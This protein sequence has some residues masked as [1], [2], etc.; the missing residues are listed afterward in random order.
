MFPLLGI[1]GGG[2]GSWWWLLLIAALLLI[3][4]ILLIG[5]FVYA[6][7]R[8]GGEAY[9]GTYSRLENKAYIYIYI[10]ISIS[11]SISIYIYIYIYIYFGAVHRYPVPAP[12]RIPLRKIPVNTVSDFNGMLIAILQNNTIKAGTW[13]A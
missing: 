12:Y 2:I 1:F 10:S 8:G 9:P 3:L 11:I 13:W 4:I 7:N 6:R 5:C